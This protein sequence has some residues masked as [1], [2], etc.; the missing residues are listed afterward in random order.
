MTFQ[1]FINSCSMMSGMRR[2]VLGMLLVKMQSATATYSHHH[3]SLPDMFDDSIVHDCIWVDMC[4][5]WQ[6]YF[7]PR[8]P[9]KSVLLPVLCNS[10]RFPF[11]CACVPE[12]SIHP[13]SVLWCLS[14]ASIPTILG[15]Y[16]AHHGQIV[17]AA[18]RMALH[19]SVGWEDIWFMIY[20]A[21]GWFESW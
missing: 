19:C 10:S 8:I 12:R 15:S 2:S 6:E 18:F 16:G 13:P 17:S 5:L 14:L 20:D 3:S 1:Y 21:D 11:C 7:C 9:T 4:L